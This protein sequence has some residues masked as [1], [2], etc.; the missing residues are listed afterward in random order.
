ME[1][2][3][4][5]EG[6]NFKIFY[7]R[8]EDPIIWTAP[9]IEKFCKFLIK[10][11]FDQKHY[12]F[13]KGF[14]NCI[15]YDKLPRLFIDP[16]QTFNPY[17][18]SKSAILSEI[19][20]YQKSEDNG[21]I[22]KIIDL[23]I[24]EGILIEDELKLFK[25]ECNTLSICKCFKKCPSCEKDLRKNQDRMK[26]LFHFPSGLIRLFYSPG[27]VIEGV[28]YHY[29][30]EEFKG[31]DNILVENNLKIS[32]EGGKERE[33]DIVVKDKIS[34]KLIV[35]HLTINSS[36]DREKSIF[37]LTATKYK[38]QTIFATI[39]K[40]KD[41]NPIITTNK[42]NPDN[43]IILWDIENKDFLSEIKKEIK[44]YFK[45]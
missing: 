10:A 13:E 16:K 31:F 37:D 30:R 20:F 42:L 12:F 29:L 3:I 2:E 8:N 5:F 9:E 35:I 11:N 4:F 6:P 24:K 43:S 36:Q 39:E 32:Q 17:D 22:K 7:P 1:R 41:N 25:C 33:I 27:K 38:I 45:L 21:D 14:N 44:K 28:V 34:N 23:F 26:K 19:E 40:E 15:Y 18:K